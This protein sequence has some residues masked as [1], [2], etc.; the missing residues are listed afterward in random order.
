MIVLHT[1]DETYEFYGKLSEIEKDERL[2]NFIKPH[3]SYYV[4]LTFIDNL[5]HDFV[6]MKTKDKIP[7]SRKLKQSVT[8]KFLTFLT[9]GC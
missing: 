1:T 6:I 9:E 5:E 8:D 4:N 2:V 3:K 7:L